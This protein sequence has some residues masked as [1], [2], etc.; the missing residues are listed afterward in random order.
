MFGQAM[1]IMN[2]VAIAQYFEAICIKIIG[3]IIV[4]LLFL[5]MYMLYNI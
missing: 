5:I 1:A 2:L 3:I 4:V